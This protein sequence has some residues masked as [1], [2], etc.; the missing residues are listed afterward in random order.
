LRYPVGPDA[1]PFLKW[2]ASMTDEQWVDWASVS[3][4]EWAASIKRDFGLDVEL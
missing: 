1:A 3:D 2:R 4:R